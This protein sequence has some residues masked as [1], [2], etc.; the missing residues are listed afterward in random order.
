MSNS[1]SAP[2]V[3]ICIP[4]YNAGNT[5]RDT[6]N[7]LLMQSY[8]NF[9]IIVSDNASTDETLKIVSEF[10]DSRIRVYR[11]EVN[12]GGEANFNR[13]LQLSSGKYTAIFHADDIY[14]PNMLEMQ[15]CFLE[16]NPKAGAAF[17]QASLINESGV[18]IGKI[19]SPKD[20]NSATY[21]YSFE[22]IFRALLRHSNFLI[23]P[24]AM[25]RTNIYQD[26]MKFWRWE[27][28]GSSADLDM[29]LRIAQRYPVCIL[30]IPL[31]RYR[32]SNSQWSA[33]VRLQTERA[34]FFRVMDFYLA[35]NDVF[36]LLNQK[37]LQSYARLERRDKVMRAINS[38]LIGQS[39][40]VHGLL[41]DIYS[42]DAI[43]SSFQS[44]RGLGV[45]MAGTY[46]NIIILLRFNKFGRKSL[47]LLKKMMHK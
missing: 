8:E 26:E 1:D 41:D 16:A 5:I 37:D 35:Q 14:E 2:L 42:W 31:M 19:N 18:N 21:L 7:S 47:L 46:L 33:E 3:S 40:D 44:K 11:N 29:W 43:I 38:F 32:I 39:K 15:V 20:F 23:C 27:L 17:T 30:P 28:F 6:L 24:S 45:L 36:A 9:E 34:D 10:K 12:I 25:V 13:C 22:T 4:A